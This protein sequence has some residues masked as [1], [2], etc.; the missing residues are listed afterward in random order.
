MIANPLSMES[1]LL[2]ALTL[3][4]IGVLVLAI[5]CL[6]CHNCIN[7]RN[8]DDTCLNVLPWNQPRRQISRS[9]TY[10]RQDPILETRRSTVRFMDNNDSEQLKVYMLNGQR[11]AEIVV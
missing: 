1:I 8:V 10:W 3:V 4:P 6:I 7:N 5:A 9:Q 11:Q 2:L